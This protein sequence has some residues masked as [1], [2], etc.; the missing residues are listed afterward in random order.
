MVSSTA[1]E[2]GAAATSAY[3]ASKHGLLGLMRA[4]A[5]DLA[6]FGVTCN[7]VCPGW[8]RTQMSERHTEVE[9]EERGLS[10]EEVWAERAAEYPA[11]R[12][13]APGGGGERDR[14]S[15]ERGGERGERRGDHGRAGLP[16]V[17]PNQTAALG[18]DVGSSSVRAAVVDRD[19]RLLGR[20]RRP[21]E[22]AMPEP[23]RFEHDPR[24]WLAGAL[25]SGREAVQDAG[26]AD[27]VVIGIGA[28][29]P[30]PVLVDERLEPL[31]PALLYGLDRRAED[32]RARLARAGRPRPPEAALVAGARP[33][34][35]LPRGLG[36]RRGW[37]P[38]RRADGPP[39]DGLDHPARLRAPGRRGERAA[40]CA[41]RA[42]RRG[43]PAATR[44]GRALGLATG[45]PV[46]AGTLDTYVDVASLG[47]APGT[48]ASCSGARSPSTRSS[49]RGSPSR[50]SS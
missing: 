8:V 11:G 18:I 28:L 48:A 44:G 37:V 40:S 34:P 20:A 33:G 2:V 31:T 21:L 24:A 1:G 29:G 4:V 14:V 35:L 10:V 32:Q 39:H 36:A 7:A 50:G 5:Q 3:C 9:A 41:G 47:V 43:R 46:T 23:G 16:L 19:G 38:G 30:A 25:E 26:D 22:T 42:A 13:V 15:R 27:V 12:V 17:R 6:P 45:T 49:P